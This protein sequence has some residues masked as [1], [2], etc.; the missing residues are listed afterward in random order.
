MI[1]TFF[2]N[3]MYLMMFPLCIVL[4]LFFVALLTGARDD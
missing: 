4:L 1:E 2:N 3:L